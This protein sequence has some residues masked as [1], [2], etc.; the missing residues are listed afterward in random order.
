MATAS[1]YQSQ[2]TCASLKV[3]MGSSV[4]EDGSVQ[5]V[6]NFVSTR[7]TSGVSDATLPDLNAFSRFMQAAPKKL[8]PE[9]LFT[10]VDLMRVALVDPRFSGYYAEEAHHGTIAP[11]IAHI[12]NLDNCPYSLR[13]V[14][15]QLACNLFS[16]PL[17]PEHILGCEVLSR[18]IIELITSSLL[19]TEHAN[20]RV[21]AASLAFNLAASNSLSRTKQQRDVLPT[22]LQIELVASLLEAI[23]DEKENAEAAKGYLL[24]LALLLYCLPAALANAESDDGGLIDLLESLDAAGALKEKKKLFPNEMLIDEVADVLLPSL[25]RRVGGDGAVPAG[26]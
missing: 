18:P 1:S 23:K 20:V 8:P 22:D 12:N 26:W 6:M 15:L 5:G 16:T 7:S 14:T 19:D 9:L 21:A 3:K 25:R 17:Y 2:A 24:A 10:V 13:I 4:S 11:L